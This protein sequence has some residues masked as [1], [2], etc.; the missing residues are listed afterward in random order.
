MLKKRPDITSSIPGLAIEKGSE[1]VTI[2]TADPLKGLKGKLKE[3][4]QEP[5]EDQPRPAKKRGKKVAQAEEA[6]LPGKP[7]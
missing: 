1:I 7:R 6:S 2:K 4:S 5:G 3:L